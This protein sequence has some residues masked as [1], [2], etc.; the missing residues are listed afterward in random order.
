LAFVP[1]FSWLPLSDFDIFLM[2]IDEHDGVVFAK[3]VRRLADT[4]DEFQVDCKSIQASRGLLS[5]WFVLPLRRSTYGS[6]L[7][8]I[9]PK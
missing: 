2:D 1:W 4:V 3:V 5:C 7:G 6:D 8:P 9:V